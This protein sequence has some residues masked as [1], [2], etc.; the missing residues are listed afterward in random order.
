V[1]VCVCVCACARV[2]SVFVYRWRP[3]DELSTRPRS[4]T[5]VND[6]ETEKSA[7]CSNKLEQAPKW[8]QRGRKNVKVNLSLCLTN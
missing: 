2:F 6:Q 4:P 8:E 3:C 1:F 7:L 5:Y